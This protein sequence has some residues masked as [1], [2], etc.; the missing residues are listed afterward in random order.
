MLQAF[1]NERLEDFINSFCK[2]TQKN[3]MERIMMR[4]KRIGKK[5]KETIVACLVGF[6]GVDG[7]Q[8]QSGD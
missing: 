5:Q 4:G 8:Y 7:E 2:S 1:V 6:Y 3:E